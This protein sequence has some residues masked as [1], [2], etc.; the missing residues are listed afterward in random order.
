MNLSC[1]ISIFFKKIP[2]YYQTA[3]HILCKAVSYK[4]TL[5]VKDPNGFS[6]FLYCQFFYE[7]FYLCP[8]LCVI[9][10]EKKK[11]DPQLQYFIRRIRLSPSG[12]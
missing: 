5:W 9:C 2:F 8:K 12:E 1:L 7:S 4:D 3:F 10:G 11:Y 6:S